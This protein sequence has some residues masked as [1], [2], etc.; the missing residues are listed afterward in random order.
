MPRPGS[1]A[2]RQRA[3]TSQRPGGSPGNRKRVP[4]APQAE[5]SAR[6]DWVH[7]LAAVVGTLAGAVLYGVV[8]GAPGGP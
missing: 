1:R 4:F 6:L 2:G 5:P 3:P 7:L 8:T